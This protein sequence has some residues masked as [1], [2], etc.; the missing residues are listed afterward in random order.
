[1]NTNSLRYLQVTASSG[2]FTKAAELLGVAQPAVSMA[3]KKLEEEYGISLFHR[4][5]RQI[6]LT[7]EG[8]IFLAHAEKIL[9][10]VDDAEL[11]MK[12]LKGLIQGTVR[13]GIPSMLGSY[14]FPPILMAFHHCFPSLEISVIEGGTLSLQKMLE[15][16]QLDLSIIMPLT[17]SDQLETRTLVREQMLVAVAREH[18]LA[19]R[20]NVT[21]KQFFREELALFHPGYIHRKIID[22]LAE[23]SGN[24]P[25]VIFETNLIPLIKSIIKQGFSI[26]T[27]LAMALEDEPDIIGL[28]FNPP[29]WL[30]LRIAWRKEGYLSKANQSFLSFLLE[31]GVARTTR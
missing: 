2:S 8:R 30:D 19:K 24:K 26:S 11:E 31:Q 10:A 4:E 5:N 27:L 23:K 13:V 25:K 28:P 18:A 6:F 7:D 12:E 16:G 9:A 29:I 20:K 22:E 1:M 17:S 15:N 21:A 3:I 14:Y